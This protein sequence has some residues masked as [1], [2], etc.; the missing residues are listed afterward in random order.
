[1]VF[2][3]LITLQKLILKT[4]I[5]LLHMKRNFNSFNR[6][7]TL[8]VLV[9]LTLSV[10]ESIAAI[11]PNDAG[12]PVVSGS[13]VLTS[14]DPLVIS[15]TFGDGTLPTNSKI[16]AT[17]SGTQTGRLFRD[18]TPST[19][20]ATSPFTVFGS[21]TNA[22]EA[23][24]FKAASS[25]CL[26]LNVTAT[27]VTLYISVYSGSYNPANYTINGIGQQGSSAIGTFAC[28]VTAGQTYVLVIQETNPAGG[29][30]T[31]YSVS[32][33]NVANAVPISIWWIVA[34]FVAI[35]GFTLYRFRLRRA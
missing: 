30:G 8:I 6:I 4:L 11:L 5:I 26:N 29:A 31:N 2:V 34:L 23:Y 22:Y 12:R 32:L 9:V 24:T 21:G 18:G 19:C 35:G 14:G 1:M 13:A 15:N 7:C 16:I 10:T 28:P 20:S 27:D 33:D 25:G 3:F 17:A